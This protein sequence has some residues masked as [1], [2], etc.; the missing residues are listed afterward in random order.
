MPSLFR[1]FVVVGAVLT[2]LLFLA[3]Y[4]L[5]PDGTPVR[6]AGAMPQQI[7]VQHDPR[8]SL[9]ER[10]RLEEA[11]RKAAERGKPM[12]P[13][14]VAAASPEPVPVNE[15]S[16]T[17]PE[18]PQMSAPVSLVTAPPAELERSTE[19]TRKAEQLKAEQA[20]RAHVARERARAKRREDAA[21]RQPDQFFYG[22]GGYA[23]REPAPAPTFGWSRTW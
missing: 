18:T 23:T 22:Y 21:V 11:A 2:G 17:R 7:S 20:R 15:P 3:S 12:A 13:T 4:L 5:A 14:V 10:L 8:A 9:V 1:Y 16:P 19:E 6:A